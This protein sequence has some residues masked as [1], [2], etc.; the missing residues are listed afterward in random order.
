LS[1]SIIPVAADPEAAESYLKRESIVGAVISTVFGIA[2]FFIFFGFSGPV[3]VWGPGN[4]AFDFIPSGFFLVFFATVVPGFLTKMK[5]AKGQLSPFQGSTT[6]LP[7]NP[8][9]RGIVLGVISAVCCGVLGFLAMKGIGADTIPWAPAF[10]SKVIIS[11]VVGYIGTR[12][13]LKA[14]LAES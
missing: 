2:F 4:Y 1:D 12:T 9:L 6:R 14:A 3:A 13:G 11:L 10:V 8:I 7:R 5:L